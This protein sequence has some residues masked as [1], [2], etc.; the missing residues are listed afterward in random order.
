[1]NRL[2]HL[3][4]CLVIGV[5]AGWP[6]PATAYDLAAWL[7]ARVAP[8]DISF[9]EPSSGSFRVETVAEGLE[10]PWAVVP[11]P[12]GR[13]FITERPGRLRLV[14]N[15]V[16][17]AR[18]VAGVP[19]VAYQGQGG[20][21]D[22]VLHPDYPSNRM[23]YLCYTVDSDAD[24]MTRVARAV[25]TAEGLKHLQVVFAG[26]PGSDKPKHFGCRIRFGLDRKLY[27]T[28]G[29]RGEGERAQNLMDLN[30][31][32]L[33]LNDDGTVPADNPFAGRRDARPEIFSYGNRNSQG[34]AVQPGTG[35]I[36]QT[37]H[38][39]SW[40]DAPG[41]GDEVNLIVA[42]GNYG[43]PLVHHRDTRE[44]TVAP[45]A[46]Y[47]PAIAPAGCMFYTGDAFPAWR[48]DFFFTNLVGKMLIRLKLD[49]PKVAGQ[50]HLLKSEFGRLRDVAQGV[51]GSVYVITSD[52][53]AY[54]PGRAGGDRLLRLVPAAK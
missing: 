21:L 41:G 38:G 16:L 44:G 53:D 24:M 9:L 30:G 32:T 43:W 13:V 37:E 5:A 34:M 17:S 4:A 48:G 54:G 28:L 27:I 11:T 49:G 26:F 40:N 36:F 12:D 18:P 14:Q 31:K 35:L 15:G 10:S 20:L 8:A 52:T 51:D 42:G 2:S 47:T 46:E 23:I 7:R 45:L 22:M 3:L 50:E 33:R 19:R 25:D 1:M 6:A 29:E 39:P